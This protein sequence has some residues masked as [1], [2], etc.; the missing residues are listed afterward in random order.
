MAVL[1]AATLVTAIAVR[2]Y[3]LGGKDLWIDE[4]NSVVL[5]KTSLVA[6]EGIGGGWNTQR[7]E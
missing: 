4:A 2:V 7:P 6:P 3:D 5:A 1:V